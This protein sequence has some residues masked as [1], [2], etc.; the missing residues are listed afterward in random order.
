MLIGL[1][2]VHRLDRFDRL[3]QHPQPA[4]PQLSG[5]SAVWRNEHPAP[6]DPTLDWFGATETKPASV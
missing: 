5:Q 3:Q 1:V 2:P 4:H 6:A